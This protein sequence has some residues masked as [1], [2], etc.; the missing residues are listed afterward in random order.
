MEVSFLYKDGLWFYSTFIEAPL[1]SKCGC[2]ILALL[3]LYFGST[4]LKGG[5]K[6]ELDFCSTF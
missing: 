3:W 6:V 5:L 4:F 1:V 2:G